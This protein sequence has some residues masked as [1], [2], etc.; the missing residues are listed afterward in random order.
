VTRTGTS[1]KPDLEFGYDAGGNRLWKKVIPKGVGETERF[2][3][4]IRDAQGNEMARYVTYTNT[5]SELLFIS[6]EH[7]LYGSA[8]IGVDGRKDT[9]Y[10]AGAYTPAWCG[11]QSARRELGRKQ[12]ELT[13]HLGNVLASISDKKAYNTLSGNIYFEAEIITLSDYYPFGSAMQTRGFAAEEYRFG[14]NNQERNGE[15]GEAYAFEYRIH[16]AR[17]GR[18]MSV[19]PLSKSYPH[20]SVFAFCEN[21]TIDGTDLEGL[22]YRNATVIRTE[23]GVTFGIYASVTPSS[24]AKT[25]TTSEFHTIDA[26]G[27]N[28]PPRDRSA[29]TIGLSGH[30]SDAIAA[31]THLAQGQIASILNAPNPSD[32][33]SFLGAP[34]NPNVAFIPN[35]FNQGIINRPL[36]GSIPTNPPMDFSSAVGQM[37]NGTVPRRAGYGVFRG[38][39]RKILIIT[40]E[41]AAAIANARAVLGTQTIPANSGTGTPAIPATGLYARYPTV[42]FALATNSGEYGRLNNDEV[43]LIG[44]PTSDYMSTSGT[45]NPGFVLNFL[46][47]FSDSRGRVRPTT[48][49]APRTL[50]NPTNRATIPTDSN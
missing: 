32:P 16:D 26:A 9:L 33:T 40:N 37:I 1:T 22:E 25:T 7:S 18:F 10:K 50:T 23:D 47:G 3:Y 11:T 15:L 2:Y 5:S 39:T 44:N 8:R 28:T 19:D 34:V 49:T 17:L 36:G 38:N 27:V 6:E 31:S 30:A 29:P 13:N 42:E 20:N 24:T 35:Q 45:A 41:S 14:F 12:Y 46:Q 48:I 4:Y 43:G 21:R